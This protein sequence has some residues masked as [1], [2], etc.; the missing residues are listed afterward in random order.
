[1]IWTLVGAALAGYQVGAA[2]L[3]MERLS[4]RWSTRLLVAGFFA[5]LMVHFWEESQA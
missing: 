2:L 1:M 3:H 4:Q 5:A